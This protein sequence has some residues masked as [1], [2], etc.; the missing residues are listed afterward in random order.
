V[1]DMTELQRTSD[2]YG[3]L[4][5]RSIFGVLMLN[6]SDGWVLPHVHLPD[7]RIWLA[8]VA[9]VSAQMSRLLKADITVL[10][11]VY[12]DY[13]EDRMH[14]DLIYELENHVVDWPLPPHAKWI[15]RPALQ[16]LPLANSEQRPIIEA[17][18][19]EAEHDHVPAKRPP[20]AR[21]GWFTSASAW[22]RDQL[23]E[24][25]MM[26]TSPIEQFKSWG[27]SSLL[28]TS[29]DHG[30]VFFK[31]ASSLPLFGNEPALLRALSDRYP[32]F[33]P[34]PIAV[35]P[36]CRWMLMGDFGAELRAMPTPEHWRT[37]VRRFG[38]LQLQTVPAVE[39]LFS[40]GCLDRR[41]HILRGQ[42]DPLLSDD[43]SLALLSQHEITQLRS[44]APRLKAMCDRLAEYRVPSTLNHGDLHSGN[45]TGESLLFFDWTDA[46]IAHPFLDLS[47]VVTDMDV[48]TPEDRQRV[49]DT[50]LNLWTAYEPMDRLH[51]MWTLAEPLGAL[52][53]AVSYQHI[54]AALEPTSRQEMIWGVPEWLRRMLKSMPQ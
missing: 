51:A 37:A 32:D 13:S 35:E 1:I 20:W 9:P 52:H 31:V 3:I 21:P 36:S 11:N 29:T 23:T 7:E 19:W 2:I 53:Q 43:D 46:C 48:F 30:D 26:L 54:L 22:M 44:L 17:I 25:N 6:V 4:L 45:I 15:D 39:E 10:R 8:M 47:T 12:A 33:V 24:Q 40:V 42:I 28:K 5:N 27:I 38:Q 50:Y 18:L 34:A 16:N 49:L 14:V 41:L